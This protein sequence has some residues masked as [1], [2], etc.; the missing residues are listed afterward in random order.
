[1]SVIIDG[2]NGITG[3]TGSAALTLA[4]P[5]FSAYGSALQ[6]VATATYTKIAFNTKEF[7]TNTNY[8]AVTNYRFTPTVAGYYQVNAIASFAAGVGVGYVAIYKNGSAF[9]TVGDTLNAT[10]TVSFPNS[11]LINF[12]GST[13][14]IEVFVYQTTGS[15]LNCG[16]AS[17]VQAFSACLV[18]S[19]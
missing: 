17:Q 15:N 7:D 9:K 13:D 12:N 14:Y 8:D 10:S 18:R 3:V 2:T 4:G 6:S 19:A 5:A 1:M 11:A 16:S